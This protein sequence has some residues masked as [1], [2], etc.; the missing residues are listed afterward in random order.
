MFEENEFNEEIRK[1]EAEDREIIASFREELSK[2]N[3]A[4]FLVKVSSLM[5]I[6]E[7]QSKYIIFQVII[8]TA[9]T[10]NENEFNEENII[11]YGKL[12]NLI[13]KF[14]NLNIKKMIDPPEFPFVLPVIYYGNYYIFMGANSLSPICLNQMLKIFSVHKEKLDRIKSNELEHLILGLLTISDGVFNNLKIN[15]EE[16]KAFNV[17]SKIKI[18]SSDNIF[19]Y[20][21]LIKLDIK[22]AIEILG[23]RYEDLTISF[24]SVLLDEVNNFHNQKF[25]KKPFLLYKDSIIILDLTSFMNLI[26]DLIIKEFMKCDSINIFNEFNQITLYNLKNDFFSIGCKEINSKLLDIVLEKNEKVNETLYLCGN[27]IVFYNLVLFDNGKNYDIDNDYYM[28][29]NEYHIGERIKYISSRI[30]KITNRIVTIVT[31]TTFGRN[32]YYMMDKTTKDLLILGQYELHTIAINEEKESLFLYRYITARNKLKYYY[33]NEFS[34]LNVVALYSNN[35]KSF[36][37]TDDVD[38]K[39]ISVLLIGEYSSDYILKSYIK[40]SCHLAKYNNDQ[41]IEVVKKDENIYHAPGLLLKRKINSLVECNNF[42]IWIFSKKNVTSESFCTVKQI[43]D[44]TSYWLSQ[45]GDYLGIIDGI[46]NINIEC[47]EFNLTPYDEAAQIGEIKF[48]IGDNNLDI[49][50]AKNSLRYFDEAG[51]NNEKEFIIKIVK[52]ILDY[53]KIDLDLNLLDEVFENQYKKKLFITNSAE[54]AHMI[55]FD[56]PLLIDIN[57]SDINLVLDEVGLFLVN[58]LKLDYGPIKDFKI[59]NDI[60]GYLYKQILK[61]IKKYNKNKLI[62]TLYTEFEKNI[63]ILLIRQSKFANDIACYPKKAK[64]IEDN[65]INLN[66]TSVALKF[67][68]ELTSSTEIKGKENIS[69]YEINYVLSIASII[70]EFAYACDVY[71]YN[72]AENTLTLLKSNRLGYNKVFFNRVN[73]VLK[74]ANVVKMSSETRE[75]RATISKY[76]PKARS[77]VPGFSEAFLDEFNFSFSEFTEVTVSLLDIAESKNSKLNCIFETNMDEVKKYINGKISNES[78][79]KVINYLSQKERD[80]YLSPPEPYKKYDVYPWR[81]NRGLSLN[82]KPLIQYNNNLVYGYRTVINSVYFLF[83]IIN[84]GTFKARS[85]LMKKYI[86]E[87]SRAKGNDFNELVYN[88][89]LCYDGLIVDKKVNKINGKR[90]VDDNNRDLGDIDILIVST[91][92]KKIFICETKNFEFSRNMYELHFEYENMYNPNNSKSF[93][94]KHMRRVNW[95]NNNMDIIKSYYD[96]PNVKWEVDYCFI[97]NEALVSNKAMKANVR[98]YTIEELDKIL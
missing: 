53:Y 1:M 87:V 35:G 81:N 58:K 73:G 57:N 4:D 37:L 70:I 48:H 78:I 65:I 16:L 95:C 32:V 11:S 12:K 20:S 66:K 39:E 50:F 75:K 59:L 97:V 46:F 69:L 63:S 40:E 15:F 3:M 13:E 93:Y 31:P 83:E 92:K 61:I 90:I 2:Y 36:Y 54:D 23:N 94:N 25:Y 76:I 26:M 29:F 85:P 42:Y 14:S 60:V 45:L 52:Y 72:M 21:K 17:D 67:L 6:P 38:S 84:N 88:Y 28:E 49:Y 98:T 96:L 7:N 24:G 91:K 68:I 33:K 77:D 56:V 79:E 9:L 62:E 41:L 44:M 51:N 80:D 64:R 5:L 71:N 89:L 30:K 10:L 27:D 18:P 74:R 19:E 82:R 43:I 22:D 86:S 8:S 34:E 55:P 47:E